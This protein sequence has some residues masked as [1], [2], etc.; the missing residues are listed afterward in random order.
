MFAL[1]RAAA[2]SQGL[3]TVQNLQASLSENLAIDL[4]QRALDQLLKLKFPVELE[5]LS[6]QI[7]ASIL[8]P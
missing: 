7:M 6:T 4:D 5:N 8:N 1:G 3:G 2:A